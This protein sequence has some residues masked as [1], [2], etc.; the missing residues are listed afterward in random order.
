M[1]EQTKVL[2]MY[3]AK[4]KLK[5]LIGQRLTVIN[6]GQGVTSEIL[7]MIKE[8]HARN[9]VDE[10]KLKF[11]VDHKGICTSIHLSADDWETFEVIGLEDEINKLNEFMRNMVTYG[12]TVVASICAAVLFVVFVVVA[13]HPIAEFISWLAL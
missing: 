3:S 9:F 6:D 5:H 1:N 2:A 12:A 4:R 13:I 10:V 7:E 8:S 11:Q